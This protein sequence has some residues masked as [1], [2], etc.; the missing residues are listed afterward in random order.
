MFL[1]WNFHRVLYVVCFVLGNST[2][3][4]LWRWSRQ[5][6]PKRR[7]IKFRLRGITQKKTC[8][9]HVAVESSVLRCL[10]V[11]RVLFSVS[12]T[13]KFRTV[14]IFIIHINS[15]W[16]IIVGIFLVFVIDFIWNFRVCSFSGLSVVTVLLNAVWKCGPGSHVVLQTHYR[17][18][19]LPVVTN[20]PEDLNLQQDRREYLTS[21]DLC[22]RRHSSLSEQKKKVGYGAT[23]MSVSILVCVWAHAS[24]LTWIC[25]TRGWYYCKM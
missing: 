5:S 9:R 7:H 4:C 22:T 21:R 18:N 16:G 11:S 15:F 2:P 17:N 20:I 25:L 10:V 6:V 23:I 13:T 3:T 24:L 8:N 14:A 19:C 12:E 1:I